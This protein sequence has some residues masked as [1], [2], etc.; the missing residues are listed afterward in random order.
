MLYTKHEFHDGDILTGEQLTYI[1]DHVGTIYNDL[2]DEK[3]QDDY[4]LVYETTDITNPKY[5]NEYGSSTFSGWYGY[6][7]T[8]QNFDKIR[9]PVKPR[10]GYLITGITVRILEMP[11]A[12]DV[13]PL[14]QGVRGSS[15]RYPS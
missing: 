14:N 5:T 2:Y 3:Q 11:A 4:H 1:D 8:P 12:A 7:G 9:F 10:D 6:V 15:P 13:T